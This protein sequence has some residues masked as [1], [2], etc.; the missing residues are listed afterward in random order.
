[1]CFAGPDQDAVAGHLPLEAGT[2]LNNC[3]AM[4]GIKHP[5]R[6]MQGSGWRVPVSPESMLTDFNHTIESSV[7]V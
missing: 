3:F 1:M 2:D 6:A 7:G 4:H 5:G